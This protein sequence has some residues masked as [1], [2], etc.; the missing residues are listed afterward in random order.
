MAKKNHEK[1]TISSEKNDFLPEK[2]DFFPEKYLVYI[3]IRTRPAQNVDVLAVRGFPI[4]YC[5]PKSPQKSLR[6]GM[7]ASKTQDG[8]DVD[9]LM[10]PD[11]YKRNDKAH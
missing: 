5:R 3:F 10:G 8:V 6:T 11:L 1:K 7:K 2:N 4:P 9:V